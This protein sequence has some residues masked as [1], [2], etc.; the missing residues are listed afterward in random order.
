VG[1]V[2]FRKGAERARTA[3]WQHW[4][5]KGKGIENINKEQQSSSE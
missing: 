2:N 4:E 1:F 3:N 5:G